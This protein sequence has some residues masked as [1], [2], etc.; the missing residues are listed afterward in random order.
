M[1]GETKIMFKTTSSLL[2]SSRIV[3]VSIKY[4][5]S[6]EELEG[7]ARAKDGSAYPGPAWVASGH[8]AS[9]RAEGV[10]LGLLSQKNYSAATAMYSKSLN[11]ILKRC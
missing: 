10:I 2:L 5:S 9:R 6:T 7:V 8:C 1:M 4:A 3:I 11:N